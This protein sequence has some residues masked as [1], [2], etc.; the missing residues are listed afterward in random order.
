[1]KEMDQKHSAAIMLLIDDNYVYFSMPFIYSLLVNNEWANFNIFIVSDNLSINYQKYI[2]EVFKDFE[3]NFHFV[4]ADTSIYKSFKATKQYPLLLYC[5][6]LPHNYISNEERVAFFDTDMIV[7]KSLKDFFEL[8]IGDNYFAAAY[9]VLSFTQLMKGIKEGVNANFMNSG[10]MIMNLQKFRENKVTIDTYREYAKQNRQVFFEEWFLNNLFYKKIFALMPFDWNYNVEMGHKYDQYCNLN[11]IEPLKAIYHFM[12][13]Q[14][15]IIKPW[16]AYEYFYYGKENDIFPED[17]YAI[18]GLW[19]KYAKQLP[20]YVQLDI[21]NQAKANKEKKLKNQ[22]ITEKNR[23]TCY[24]YVLKKLI[25]GEFLNITNCRKRI[26]KIFLESG[27]KNIAIYG[28][29]ELAKIL[30]AILQNTEVNIVYVV[31]N[32]KQ[33]ISDVCVISRQATNFPMV[34]AMFVAD[35]Y[36]E[37]KIIIEMSNKKVPFNVISL[38]EY[39]MNI[40]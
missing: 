22:I 25:C 7:V 15:S 14:R 27:Y 4:N 16:D 24:Y 29:M 36:S 2:I 19:W 23:W 26:E 35:I 6:M 31:E 32:L 17:I 21:V 38:M 39:L 12:N 34:D 40:K 1:M 37:Q 9:G 33:P 3:V 18:Y 20:I 30:M 11:K 10:A 8:D 13:G 5:K 28:Y